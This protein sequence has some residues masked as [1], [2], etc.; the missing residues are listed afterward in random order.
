[1]DGATPSRSLEQGAAAERLLL[2][3]PFACLAMV[4]PAASASGLEE[5]ASHPLLA[6]G[7]P[8]VV[9]LNFAYVTEDQPAH[10]RSGEP[11][12]RA[13]ATGLD[14]RIYFHTGE[15]RKSRALAADPRVCLAV[16][17]EVA[18]EQGNAPCEDAF[19]YRSLLVWGRARKIEESAERETA[20]R[21][22]VAK[23]DPEAAEVPFDQ[24]VFAATLLY[25]L[26]IDEVGYKERRPR[27]LG[28]SS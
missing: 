13:T 8:Y 12:H 5:A 27:R 22:L 28:E 7:G 19:S 2:T 10:A 20:L 4:E 17:A 18:F 21:F 3:A 11:S 15:G 23:Y 24:D 16:T 6:C 9:P 14:G 26:T 25:E 1:M